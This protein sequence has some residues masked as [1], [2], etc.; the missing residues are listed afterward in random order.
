MRNRA[1]AVALFF[2]LLTTATFA[3]YN[4]PPGAGVLLD[5]YSPVFLAGGS[6]TVGDS[7]PAADALNPAASGAK[8]RLTFDLNG[9]ALLGTQAPDD[10]FGLALNGGLGPPT[11]GGVIS[12]SLHLIDA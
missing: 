2:M 12:G 11:R 3:Q 6:S 5:L 1:V 7:S 10:G 8:Q 9:T 4:P